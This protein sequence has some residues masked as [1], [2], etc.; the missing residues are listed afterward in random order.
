MPST[1]TPEPGGL[2]WYQA[3]EGLENVMRDRTV[4]GVDVVELAPK[5]GMHASD[6]I[7]AKLVYK[8]M[9]LIVKNSS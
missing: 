2:S 3:L 5:P 8:I 9:D 7:A 1:G 6:F 4:I